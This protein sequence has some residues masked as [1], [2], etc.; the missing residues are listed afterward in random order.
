MPTERLLVVGA[1]TMGHGIAHVGAAAGWTVHLHDVDDARIARGIDAVRAN[2][3]TGVAK[4]KV[5]PEQRD[6]TLARIHGA[7]DLDAAA[8][9][10]TIAV[11]AIHESLEAKRELF[12][13]LSGAAPPEALLAT[14][15]SSLPVTRIAESARAP[16]RILGMHFFNPV[17][18]MTLLEVVR[19]T[20]T[21]EASVVRAV[22]LGRQ[23]GKEPIVVRDAPG[24]A[25]S[26]LGVLLGLEAM[27]M[28]EQGV[29]SA[30]DIDKA[31]TLGYRHPVGPL[32]LSDQIG[33]DVRLAI[34]E[35]L[36]GALGSEAF[37][38]PEIL[39][40]LVAEGRL[41]RKSGSGFY[42][43]DER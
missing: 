10:C 35:H 26:R 31:M 41:G 24:F 11:E 29:A 15:T 18:L 37:R 42:P 16:E 20:A 30:E 43:W 2:L 25:T 12:R 14:N 28:V 33:L 3:D 17:H 27:R 5:T 22:A 36:H 13:R 1:G 4:G 9:E 23:L 6:A 19:G 7:P 39:R 32:R 21:S 34:A 38:P 40:R 8:A